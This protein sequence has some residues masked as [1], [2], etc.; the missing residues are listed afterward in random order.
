MGHQ[1]PN[2]PDEE[3]KLK[4]IF[5]HPTG[6]CFED[7]TLEFARLLHADRRLFVDPTFFLV[8]GICGP[9]EDVPRPYS[10]AW[11]EHGPFV[12]ASGYVGGEF[13]FL[14]IPRD[15]FYETYR[16]V[17]A[18][19]YSPSAALATAK[20]NNDVPPPW[21]ERYRVLCRDYKGEKK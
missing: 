3:T 5:F 14:V 6:T 2:S 16:V 19:K 17:E 11:I 21:E 1:V 20:R 9:N 7:C 12:H 18:T 13:G 10:H 8:H 15:H 4:G